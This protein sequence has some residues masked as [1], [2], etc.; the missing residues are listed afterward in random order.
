MIVISICVRR[1]PLQRW[2][3][4]LL[5]GILTLRF[6]ACKIFK[7]ILVHKHQDVKTNTT[8][9]WSILLHLFLSLLLEGPEIV[10]P[11]NWKPCGH[12]SR[13]KSTLNYAHLSNICHIILHLRKIFYKFFI[14]LIIWIVFVT[15][16]KMGLL[17]L[18]LTVR[19]K[20]NISWLKCISWLLISCDPWYQ[21]QFYC[22]WVLSLANI[23]SWIFIRKML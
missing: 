23:T 4:Q 16:I 1:A 12:C 9:N 11:L 7:I 8:D 22:F 6:D 15:I 14:E 19:D 2:L 3:P 21:T 10:C 17:S 18:L 5:T 20:N 13:K